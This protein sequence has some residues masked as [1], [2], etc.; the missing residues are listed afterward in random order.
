MDL[1][2]RRDSAL[3][4]GPWVE[5][6]RLEAVLE[7]SSG[8]EVAA[9]GADWV[10]EVAVVPER[11]KVGAGCMDVVPG[12]LK[13]GAGCVDEGVLCVVVLGL[14]RLKVGAGVAV[15]AAVAGVLKRLGVG[16]LVV[17]PKRPKD[18]ADVAGV[19]VVVVP[20]L[21]VGAAGV[22]VAVGRLPNSDGFGTAGAGTVPLAALGCEV[23]RLKSDLGAAVVAGF[24]PKAAE[25]E[26]DPLFS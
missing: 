16:V 17:F 4:R 6:L 23:G 10:V 2:F 8:F 1:F 9:F 25:V 20:E 3:G 13:L 15:D 12:R 19:P 18:G 22:D 14:D 5:A 21:D 26:V 7:A 24:V 11:L